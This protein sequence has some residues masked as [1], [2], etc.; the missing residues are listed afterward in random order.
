M[1]LVLKTFETEEEGNKRFLIKVQ[2]TEDYEIG[3]LGLGRA[4][5]HGGPRFVQKRKFP[6][7]FKGFLLLTERKT[8]QNISRTFD[9]KKRCGDV[10]LSDVQIVA[11]KKSV[12]N[13]AASIQ[14]YEKELKEQK[15]FINQLEERICDLELSQD[16]LEQYM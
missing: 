9:F 3:F 12:E 10:E 4:S 2:N 6:P 11:S 14:K 15:S 8:T 13:V 7:I 5:H 16:A 1:Y